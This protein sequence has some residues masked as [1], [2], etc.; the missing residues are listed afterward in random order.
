MKDLTRPRAIRRL[1]ALWIVA[2]VTSSVAGCDNKKT[3]APQAAPSLAPSSDKDSPPPASA[4]ASPSAN[5]GEATAKAL[6]AHPDLL[7]QVPGRWGGRIEAHLRGETSGVACPEAE[8]PK[9]EFD[10]G[11][12]ACAAD[13]SKAVGFL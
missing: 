13:N 2:A 3:D 5:V 6:A 1:K 10:K 4:S 8:Q 11:T 12:N 7:L 9:N